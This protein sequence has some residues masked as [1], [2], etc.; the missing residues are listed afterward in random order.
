M[1]TRAVRNQEIRSSSRVRQVESSRFSACK[2][3]NRLDE[4][5]YVLKPK[6]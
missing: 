6:Y 3:A 4:R 5:R 2:R 1:C